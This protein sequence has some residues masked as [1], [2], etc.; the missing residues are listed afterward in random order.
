M[1]KIYTHE[2]RILVSNAQNI[3]EINGIAT[4]LKNEFS[5]GAMGEIAPLETWME[6]WVVN[7][8]DYEKACELIAN[9]ISPANAIDWVCQYC[10]ETNDA[11]FEIC[12]QCGKE[13]PFLGK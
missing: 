9:A 4:Y 6:V 8:E 10:K 13:A 12:W 1:R 3:L 7:N 11:S 2:N 5:A